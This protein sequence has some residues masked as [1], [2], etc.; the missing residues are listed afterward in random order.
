MTTHI[1]SQ[2]IYG[3]LVIEHITFKQP[4]GMCK[5]VY[6]VGEKHSLKARC[7][8]KIKATSFIDFMMVQCTLKPDVTIGAIYEESIRGFQNTC[9]KMPNPSMLCEL[10]A[11]IQSG[12]LPPNFK[13]FFGDARFMHP[14][15]LLTSLYSNDFVASGIYFGNPALRS[16]IDFASFKKHVFDIS[17][18]LEKLVV[19]HTLHRPEI[20]EFI[21]DL[22]FPDQQIPQWYADFLSQ[23]YMNDS[24][25]AFGP[26][27][28]ASVLK[29]MLQILKTIDARAYTGLVQYV[30]DILD[31]MLKENGQYSRFLEK[32]NRHMRVQSLNLEFEKNVGANTFMTL[33]FSVVQDVYMLTHYFLNREKYDSYMFIVGA[34]HGQN[35]SQFLNRHE[36]QENQENQE[37]VIYKSDKRGCID[38]TA[39]TAGPQTF[40]DFEQ[41]QHAENYLSN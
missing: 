26:Q 25:S 9:K 13:L 15:E 32:I 39:F 5:N 33:L 31:K 17:K 27:T 41:M 8:K 29:T 2:H 14:F 24:L 1:K 11:R 21:K 36:N 10:T 19:E 23:L 30:D 18:Q 22:I 34:V 3:P 7:S 37:S 28:T 40:A 16:V 35:M 38:M 4:I 6:I 12:N 20:R